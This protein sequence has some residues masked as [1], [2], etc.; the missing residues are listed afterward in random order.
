MAFVGF[1]NLSK[2][3]KD[4]WLAP[5][6]MEML[7]VELSAATDIV[8]KPDELV[9]AA[10]SDLS[11][12]G[13]GGY[14][15][16]T[17]Q[18]LRQRLDADYVI[19][20]SYLVNGSTEDA[21]LRV[22]IALQDARDGTLVASVSTEAALPELMS[23][24][25]RAGAILRSKLGDTSLTADRLAEVA[26]LQP[27]TVDVARHVGFALDALRAYDPARA[28]DE[29]MQAIAEAPGYA[30]AYTILA[31]AWSD[32]GYHEKSRIAA[33]Q[34]AH[35]AAKLP[36]EQRLHARGDGVFRAR[37]TRRKPRG[38]GSCWSNCAPPAWSTV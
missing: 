5:A 3:A 32:L 35:W 26:N 22:D 17:L 2:N 25:T 16:G 27:P 33:E 28:H 18:R 24:V 37:R 34:A 12:P 30:P 20:G 4:A 9:R 31:Q 23:L 1:S 38:P 36:E 14:A 7:G 29:V 21:P 6:L 10:S 19:S 15:N 11:A 13:A 8:V